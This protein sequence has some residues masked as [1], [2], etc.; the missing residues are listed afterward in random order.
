VNLHSP[1]QL[2]L[3]FSATLLL[4]NIGLVSVV[5]AGI[6]AMPATE[7]SLPATERRAATDADIHFDIIENM[8]AE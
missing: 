5:C 8:A 3:S 6:L 4:G 1:D 7:I 2:L